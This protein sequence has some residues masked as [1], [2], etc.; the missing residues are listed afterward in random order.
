MPISTTRRSKTAPDARVTL[1]RTLPEHQRDLG[2]LDAPD[3]ACA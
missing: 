2:Q 1:R 3:R